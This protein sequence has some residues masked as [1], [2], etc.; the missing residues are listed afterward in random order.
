MQETSPRLEHRDAQ[1]FAAIRARM[2]MTKVPTEAPPLIQRVLDW[3]A[4]KGVQPAGPLFF[5]YP[6]F[7]GDDVVVDVGFPVDRPLQADGDGIVTGV[8]PAGRYAVAVLRGDYSGIPA[9][10][11]RLLDWGRANGVAWDASPDGREWASRIE[12]YPTDPHEEPDPQKWETE[13]AI[14][15]KDGAR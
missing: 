14:R 7:D 9:A 5:R 10:T 6:T 3:M 8:L 11:G 13:L 15:V 4:S 12:W 2:A 1:P